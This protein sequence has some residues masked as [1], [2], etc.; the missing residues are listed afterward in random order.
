MVAHQDDNGLSS[1]PAATSAAH[2][3]SWLPRIQ[4]MLR[5]CVDVP[6]LA[7]AT[8]RA[9]QQ[10]AGLDYALLLLDQ[11]GSWSVAASSAA[12]PRACSFPTS[13]I[14]PLIQQLPETGPLLLAEADARAAL[15]ALLL[16]PPPGP[17]A[18][19]GLWA[20]DGRAAALELRGALICGCPTDG[21]LAVHHLQALEM[22]ATTAAHELERQALVN[23]LAAR[24]A[25]QRQSEALLA[26]INTIAELSHAHGEQFRRL[27]ERALEQITA[28]I[29]L[30]TGC[31][32]L[33]EQPARELVLVA[34]W[35]HGD[36]VA[37][38]G[39][40]LSLDAH[41]SNL[42]CRAFATR[43]P[44]LHEA[45]EPGSGDRQPEGSGATE[46]W[47]VPLLAAARSI[48]VLLIIATPGQRL[49]AAHQALLCEL[50]GKLAA[51]IEHA[52]QFNLA[53]AEQERTRAL[54][55]ASND[56][57]MLL[58]AQG[59]AIMIN[60][61]AKYFFG[62]AE[63]DVL[64]RSATQLRAMFNLIFEDSAAFDAWLTPLLTSNEERAVID[65]KVL[66]AEPRLLQCFTAPVL[67]HQER[68][69]GR[70]LVFRDITREREV[71][72][73]KN[74]FV[75]LVSHELRTPLTSIRGALQLV[76]G[77]PQAGGGTAHESMLSPR[78]RE[79]LT[80]S[81]NNSERLIRLINDILDISKIE[82]GRIQL[83]RVAI[84]P[85][86]LCHAAA[87][88]VAAF[89]ASRHTTIEVTVPTGLPPVSADRDRALQVLAN[90]LSNAIKFSDAGQRVEVTA[91]AVAGAVRFSV[92][93][94]GRGIAPEHHQRIF[95]K[96]QQLDSTA[97]RDV[98]GTGLGLAIC[99]ALVEE[100]GG[101]IWLDSAPGQGSTFAFTL[102]L[103]RGAAPPAPRDEP[104][105]PTILVVDDNPIVCETLRGIL[106][107]EGYAV[108]EAN[109]GTEAL[110]L[111][112]L[113]QPALITLDVMLPDLDGFD[114]IQIL[115]NDPLTRDL[116]VLFIS[117]TSEHA[118]GLELGG[119]GFL[120]K[121][122]SPDELRDQVRRLI[123]PPQRR[124]LVVDDDQHVR[125][126]LVRMLERAGFQALEAAGGLE[127]IDRVQRDAPDL[128]LLDIRM[129]DMDGYEVLR[130]LKRHPV[131]RQIP[132]V[133]LTASDLGDAVRQRALELGAARYL[134]KPIATE[135]LIAEIERILQER[136]QNTK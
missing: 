104:A 119:S 130:W 1:A 51:A 105:R 113:L 75:S 13:V 120:T 114:V 12:L 107:E 26:A 50:A 106:E 55:D 54:V 31:I 18:V 129:P 79:L 58:D 56:A 39:R 86:E 64:G 27:L 70:L 6:A 73:M 97:T 81:L 90:L 45:H 102:P 28:V 127:A 98:G 33:H 63:R 122:F 109:R 101:Q 4:Q 133:V 32:Y 36:S 91:A 20:S 134:E 132:V 108:A 110:Q 93:D 126:M 24:A 60:R 2:A 29:G 40:R 17:I 123:A 69:L 72:R 30:N 74:E 67:D 52:R 22:L 21:P 80:V 41:A 16:A 136:M 111:A 118:R 42:V 37:R 49:T 61:R 57:I 62:L 116:P 11:A 99:K 92:R 3:H 66:R 128:I 115:R 135:D 47:A 85:G 38:Y 15:G 23:E 84:D 96:F 117:A 89:A 100:H 14:Q 78:T 83:Q 43:E 34:A 88:E 125:P 44:L 8:V 124:V 77:R 94:Y 5:G 68:L 35:P 48:G 25:A 46:S 9:A 53:R 82:Q 10:L 121:P 65:L 19:Y 95:E 131:H 87:Q 7:Q 103:A 76:L 71:E 59:R 112:R